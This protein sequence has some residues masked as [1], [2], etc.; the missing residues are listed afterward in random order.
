MR[1][2]T[3]IV[4]LPGEDTI[5]FKSS[6]LAELAAFDL[7]AGFGNRATDVAAYMNAGLTAER[8]FIKLPEFTDELSGDLMAGHAFGFD[9]YNAIRTTNLPPLMP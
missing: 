8:I 1:L 4:T 5:E 3:S 7:I 9:I 2:P 6:A